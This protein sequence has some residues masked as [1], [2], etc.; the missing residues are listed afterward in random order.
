MNKQ[1]EA[2]RM[3]KQHI[4]ERK[5]GRGGA[6]CYVKSDEDVIKAIDEA[7]EQQEARLVSYAPDKSTCT[8]NID[9]EEVYFNREQPAQEHVAWM[10]LHKEL[11]F[12]KWIGADDGWDRAIE[13]VRKRLVELS[14]TKITNNPIAIVSEVY[15]SRYTI[16][17][18]NG[19]FPEGTKLYTHPAPSWQ[20]LSQEEQWNLINRSDIPADYDHEILAI[21]RAIEQSLKEKNKC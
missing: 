10:D 3:A 17:W 12:M 2:L 20:G 18:I 11:G 4:I 13:A 5:G 6:V 7:L 14:T 9:G 19:S 16:E 21:A 8:L 1:T 15:Q